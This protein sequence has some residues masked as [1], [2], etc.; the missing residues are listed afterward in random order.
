MR[1]LFGGHAEV[2]VELHNGGIRLRK[3]REEYSFGW[4]GIGLTEP[5]ASEVRLYKRESKR[6][7]ETGDWREK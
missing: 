5:C 1:S 6:G 7:M 2:R 3:A 4:S